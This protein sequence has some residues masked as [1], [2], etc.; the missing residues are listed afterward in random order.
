[1]NEKR[2][3]KRFPI[4]LKLEVSSLFRQDND[5]VRDVDAPIEVK[6]ISKS[7]IGFES[8]SILPLDYYFNAKLQLGHEQSVLYC[9][10]KII[11]V[12][13]LEEG[14]FFYGC[15]FVGM[16]PVLGYIFDNY[17]KELASLGV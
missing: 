12:R 1:M 14:R 7:G 2:R 3:D 10:V 13:K 6:D 5:G 8:S 11:R 4:Q 9:V 16:A 17:E 15:E